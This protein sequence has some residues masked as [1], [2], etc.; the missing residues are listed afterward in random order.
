MTEANKKQLYFCLFHQNNVIVQP[1]IHVY[2][3]IFETDSSIRSVVHLIHLRLLSKI[4]CCFDTL[5]NSS[6]SISWSCL[7]KS[8]RVNWWMAEWHMT[9]ALA[10]IAIV[11]SMIDLCCGYDAIGVVSLDVFNPLVPG[12]SNSIFRYMIIPHT[13]QSCWGYIGFTLSVHQSVCLSVRPSVRPASRVRSVTRTVLVGSIFGNF[14]K[15]VTLTL[16]SFDLGSDVNH[17]HG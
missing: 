12:S 15:F 1:S 4:I 5:S 8:V 6:M 13:Q 16:S 10:I 2:S 3:D 7:H 14:L 17:W 9:W 11:T